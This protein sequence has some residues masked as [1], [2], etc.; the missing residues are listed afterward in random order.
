MAG[1]KSKSKEGWFT[2]FLDMVQDWSRSGD[3][4]LRT[5][6][7]MDGVLTAV[8]AVFSSFVLWPLLRALDDKIGGYL[9]LLAAIWL[10]Y[11]L[12]YKVSRECWNLLRIKLQKK[13]YRLE[14]I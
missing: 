1:K 13:G 2:K 3:K 10:F 9:A 12:P 5:N 14:R 11:N 7:A 8:C 4:D 6:W